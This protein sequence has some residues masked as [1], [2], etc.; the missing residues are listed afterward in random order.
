MLNK[1]S[2]PKSATDVSQ[3]VLT[4]IKCHS[5]GTLRHPV[6][7]GESVYLPKHHSIGIWVAESVNES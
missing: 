5:A 3:R 7:G 1:I 2:G 4:C 6:W